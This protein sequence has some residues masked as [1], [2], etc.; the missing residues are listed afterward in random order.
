MFPATKVGLQA[1]T[2]T[3]TQKQ[4]ILNAIA[5]YVNDID[6]TNAATIMAQYTAEIDNT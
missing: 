4:L 1:N 5:T 6:D 2:L 3:S